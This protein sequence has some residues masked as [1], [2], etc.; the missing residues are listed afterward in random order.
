MAAPKSSESFGYYSD[1]T[2]DLPHC[3]RLHTFV[4]FSGECSRS[5]GARR[6]QN[7]RL[8][9]GGYSAIFRNLGKRNPVASRN[10]GDFG[11]WAAV[12]RHHSHQERRIAWRWCSDRRRAVIA[13]QA[14]AR[15]RPVHSVR[16]LSRWHRQIHPI[17]DRSI[18]KVNRQR[19][20]GPL[21]VHG[22]P[23][24]A[25]GRFPATSLHSLHQPSQISELPADRVIQAL[26]L[27][28]GQVVCI[29]ANRYIDGPRWR[30]LNR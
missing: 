18:V 6:Y 30:E 29:H 8:D 15:L 19:V 13:C 11:I 5:V 2:L 24:D 26:G 27:L 17:P 16:D 21:G 7:G 14:P 10:F 28:R 9:R 23:E 20:H 12:R 3:K 22:G 4:Y 1:F 25:V